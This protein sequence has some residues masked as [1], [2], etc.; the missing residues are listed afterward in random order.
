MSKKRKDIEEQLQKDEVAESIQELTQWVRT[1]RAWMISAILLILVFVVGKAIWA[2]HRETVLRETNALMND[3]LMSYAQVE[4]AKED[5]QREEGMKSLMSA[6][7]RLIDSYPGT[8][9]AREAQFVKG[10]AYYALDKF[11]EAQKTFQEYVEKAPND[12]ERSRGEIALAYA[13]ENNS[14]LV[15]PA[16]Q[17]NLLDQAATHYSLAENYAQGPDAAQPAW[18]YLYYYALMGRARI[19]E[20]TNKPQEAIKIYEKVIADRPVPIPPEAKD[21]KNPSAESDPIMK[22]VTRE[23]ENR[24]A[25]ISFQ[26]TAKL[27]LERLKA[28]PTGPAQTTAT[29]QAVNSE[30]APPVKTETPPATPTAKP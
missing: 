25:Q 20:V 2:S 16:S 27:R 8:K 10:K 28:T 14:F 29:A 9:L 30:A 1:N 22:F 17:K 21:E 18:P 4:G 3:V 24:S 23:I 5:V 12:E 19:L 13:F 6:T 26:A 7:A 11:Q 15:P